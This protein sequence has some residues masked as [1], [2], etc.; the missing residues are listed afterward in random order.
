MRCFCLAVVAAVVCQELSCQW[1]FA[2]SDDELGP[3]Q[4]PET[5]VEARP[6]PFPTNPLAGDTLVTPG[7]GESLANTTASSI[8]V[9]TRDQIEASRH[10][11]VSEVLRGISGVDVVQAGGL[12]RQ[13]SIFMRGANSEHTKVLID[14]IPANDP[15]GPTRAFDFS[16][17]SLDNVERIEVVRGP[18]SM[19][20]GSDAIGGVINIITRR[21][22][23][24]QRVLA[25]ASGGS[26]GTHEERISVSGGDH[27]KY[28]SVGASYLN[29]NGFS[30]V[31]RRLGG[32]EKDGFQRT[33]VSGRFGWTP[34]ACI[35]VDYVFRFTAADAEVDDYLL[36]NLMRENQ[37]E[38]F[39]QRVQIASSALD[40]VIENKVGFSLTDYQRIDTDPG[41]FGTP[42][43]NGQTS[44]VDWQAGLLLTETN[45]LVTG[46]DYWQ[47]EAS[48]TSTPNVP[49]S[50]AGVYIED[51]FQMGKRSF[52]SI[53]VRWDDHSTAGSAETYRLTQL[54]RFDE[55]GTRIHGSIGRGFR[56]PSIAQSSTFFFLGDPSLRPEF[57]KGW[58]I[59]VEQTFL[60]GALVADATYFRNNFTNLIV[61]D[62]PSFSLQNVGL[63]ESR[64]I[65]LTTKL[66]MTDF[67]SLNA[68]YTYND[69]ENLITN[70]Q[71]LRRPRHKA[72]VNLQQRTCDNRADLNLYLLY[73]GTRADFGTAAVEDL[74]T[75]ITLNVSGSYAINDHWR[76]FARLENLTDT[77][78]EE[79]F[80]FATPGISGYAGL[81][82]LR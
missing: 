42:E 44:Q 71:L 29:T 38:Q 60:G 61:F 2:Q 77:D 73:V 50:Q 67:T 59:G 72:S 43:F 62:F 8:T 56:A 45:R 75:Y 55:T 58:D 79:V 52:T 49:R 1:L 26:F 18:Q 23:G 66:R 3:L 15:S 9:I 17:L 19:V 6:D 11:S 80:G 40:G 14:G 82:F 51:R 33:A 7:R 54:F 4:L 5:V 35:N 37:T 30:A 81:T 16:T 48:T 46:I 47:E 32:L 53:G 28:Y 63:A 20:Y 22:D 34:S 78:Y 70:S 64:G 36:D 74:S 27:N 31:S 39:F 68:S 69:T 65:E 25:S 24:A 76:A 21:A 13:T 12:G 10:S 41:I 57:S